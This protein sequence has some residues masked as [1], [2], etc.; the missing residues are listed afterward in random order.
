MW[1]IW[2]LTSAVFSAFCSILEKKALFDLDPF[3][4]A[5]ALYACLALIFGAAFL[6]AGGSFAAIGQRELLS[7][8]IKSLTNMVSFLLIMNGIRRMEL[9]AGLPLMLLA[10]ALVALFAYCIFGD[11]LSASQA[12]GIALMTL[13]GYLLVRANGQNGHGDSGAYLYYA[14]ALLV[15][16]ASSLLN[17]YILVSRNVSPLDFA[18]AEHLLAL[19]N[20]AFAA[21]LLRRS[22]APALRA[23]RRLPFLLAGTAAGTAAYRFSEAAA[24]AL[25]NPALVV[26]LKRLSVVLAVLIGGRIFKERNL[27]RRTLAAL[28]MFGGVWLIIK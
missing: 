14:A 7:I 21:L 20:F 12:G 28:V 9:S 10:P 5:L 26:A 17:R 3:D 15:L 1:M 25:A 11:A 22:P 2:S 19:A 8:Y 27:A 24:T 23:L 18:A 13:G 16:T 4:F 6:L